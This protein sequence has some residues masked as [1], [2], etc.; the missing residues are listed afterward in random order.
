MLATRGPI[1]VFAFHF[2]KVVRGTITTTLLIVLSFI[3]TERTKDSRLW[4][5]NCVPLYLEKCRR[6][7]GQ[8][9]IHKDLRNLIYKCGLWD[10]ERVH[11]DIDW[12]PYLHYSD[13]DE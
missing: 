9:P 12:W 2:R 6:V 3:G 11:E 7:L 13:S 1:V 8:L 10:L 5:Y 4:C